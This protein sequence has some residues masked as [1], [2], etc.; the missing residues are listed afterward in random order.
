MVSSGA[1]Q[2]GAHIHSVCNSFF[3]LEVGCS[4]CGGEEKFLNFENNLDENM[5]IMG[6]LYV[7]VY[8]IVLRNSI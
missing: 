1:V 3:L 7:R 2:M 8:C 5:H 6:E 4:Y